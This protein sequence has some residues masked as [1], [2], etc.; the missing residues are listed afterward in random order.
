MQVTFETLP[1][2]VTE[3]SQ[4][5]KEI[6]Q[7]LLNRSNENT[8]EQDQILTVKQAAYFLKLSVPTLYGYVQRAEIPVSKKGK[9]LY[10]SRKELEEWIKTGKKKTKEEIQAEANS[11]VKRKGADRG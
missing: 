9:R 10:F 5:I 7:I 6:K 11:Y 3:L 4:E 2:A 1:N 8:V